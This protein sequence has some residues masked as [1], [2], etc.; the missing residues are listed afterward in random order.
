MSK[1]GDIPKKLADQV[2]LDFESTHCSTTATET[3]SRP[4]VAPAAPS[5]DKSDHTKEEHLLE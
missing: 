2:P 1:L 4:S 5:I 3:P